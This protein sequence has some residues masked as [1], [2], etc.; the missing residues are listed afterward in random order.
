MSDT[1]Y[2]NR[3]GMKAAESLADDLLAFLKTKRR[4]DPALGV[5]E[6]Q[7]VLCAA[8]A[9]F[10]CANS[11]TMPEAVDT[12]RRMFPYLEACARQNFG[13]IYESSRP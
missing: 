10:I 12:M 2:A 11:E 1:Y 8:I 7:M 6:V 4:D 9:A 3:D 13:S 5:N